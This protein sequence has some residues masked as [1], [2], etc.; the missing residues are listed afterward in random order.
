LS[1][2]CL[3]NIAILLRGIVAS[4]NYMTNLQ[5]QKIRINRHSGCAWFVGSAVSYEKFAM[6]TWEPGTQRRHAKPTDPTIE[7][8]DETGLSTN[9]PAEQMLSRNPAKRGCR[10]TYLPSKAGLPTNCLPSNPARRIYQPTCPPSNPAR[11]GY[12]PICPPSNLAEHKS[13]CWKGNRLT[14]FLKLILVVELPNT[15]NWTK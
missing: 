2:L 3:C 9:P 6:R 15:N 4:E 8:P 13:Y 12:R 7:W 1:H 5:C 10:S 11:R 14:P